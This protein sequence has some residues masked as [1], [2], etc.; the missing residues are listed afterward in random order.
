MMTMMMAANDGAAGGAYIAVDRMMTIMA[1]A[2][3]VP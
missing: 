2:A 3:D 1:A